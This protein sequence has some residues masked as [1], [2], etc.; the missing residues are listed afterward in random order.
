MECVLSL[1]NAH[2]GKHIFG[3]LFGSVSET[4]KVEKIRQNLNGGMHYFS[5]SILTCRIECQF[6]I[7]LKYCFNFIGA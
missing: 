7:R 1:L 6:M 4:G 3:H 5:V 2:V